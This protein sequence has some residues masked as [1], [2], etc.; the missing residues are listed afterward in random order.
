MQ[1]A[2]R[3]GMSRRSLLRGLG[4]SLALPAFES[5]ASPARAAAAATVPTRMA[6]LYIPNG[7]NVERWM[8][9]GTGTD[10][11]F[12]PSLEALTSFRGD[13]QFIRG[14]AQQHGFAGPDGAG[15]HARAVATILT[16]A[17]PRKTAGADIKA[18]VSVDQVA[19]SVIGTATRFP[20]LELSCDA[21]RKSGNC[22]SGYSCAY[23]F[24]MSWRS[25]NQPATAET[26]PRLVFERLFGA[27]SGHERAASLAA[28]QQEQ[29]SILDFVLG[30]ARGLSDQ[31]G[32]TDRRKLDEYLTGVREIEQRVTAFQPE[33]VANVPDLVLPDRPPSSYA[34][35]IRLMAD[36]M[37][38]AFQTDSTRIATFMLAHDGSNRSFPEVGVGD[39]HHNLSH[40]QGK[41]ENLEKIAR[42]DRF[43]GE[44][45]AYVLTRMKDIREENGRSL[46][47]NSMLLYTSGLSDGNRHNHNDLPVIM[48]GTAGG[49]LTTGRNLVLPDEQPMSNLFMT[50]LDLMG[51]PQD[52][53]GDS[54]GRLDSV[55]A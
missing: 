34:D 24:N 33:S 17:R 21:S 28:R 40:H 12:G 32:T 25:E 50:M 48:A 20:S 46:L 44:Q 14:L 22:D 26:N 8:P 53:F 51:A 39:G 15:D 7:V 9:T 41:D 23:S 27:G 35:H 36:M 4:I 42:I 37:V 10:Y 38:L 54:T 13:L 29:K 19:A 47:D 31:L 18:G 1:T 2:R 6:F 16:G 45:L 43:Y 5:L 49:R 30:E 55:L 11:S 3:L 52:G